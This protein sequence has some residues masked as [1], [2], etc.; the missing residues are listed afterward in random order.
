MK[1]KIIPVDKFRK[2]AKRLIK[3]YPSLKSELT[4]LSYALSQTP[5]LGIAL[6]NEAYKIR[7]AI[8]SKGK[9]KSGGGRVITYVVTPNQEVY[10]LTIYDKAEFDTID[11]KTL[12]RI[13]DTLKFEK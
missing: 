9:G 7:V 13:I 12:R 6:G 3:K 4:E 1:Y 5:T 8:K 10:L 2:E 11:D